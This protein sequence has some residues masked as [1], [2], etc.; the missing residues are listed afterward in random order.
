MELQHKP[1]MM[2]QLETNEARIIEVAI[3]SRKGL[4]ELF[5]GAT[6]RHRASMRFC[7]PIFSSCTLNRG[8]AV[9]YASKLETVRGQT[10][11]SGV[12]REDPRS[13][14]DLHGAD[15]GKRLPLHEPRYADNVVVLWVVFV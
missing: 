9:V 10:E 7:K 15:M 4:E 14:E 12:L 3:W 6:V 2:R 5:R 13:I 8:A 1:M 11:G